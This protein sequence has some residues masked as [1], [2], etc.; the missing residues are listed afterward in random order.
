MNEVDDAFEPTSWLVV[1]HISTRWPWLDRLIPGRFKHVS[2]LCW[3]ASADSWLIYDV[4]ARR[5]SV[6]IAK[7]SAGTEVAARIMADNGVLRV[8]VERSPQRFVCRVGFWC[9]PAI[10]HLLGCRSGALL[11]ARLW[12]DLV[13]EGAEVV[14]DVF[15]TEVRS[16]R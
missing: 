2:A 10:R 9:V 15:R 12:R 4:S 13:A 6:K 16:K 1:F 11:P 7:G 8:Q 3:V 14:S 5:T